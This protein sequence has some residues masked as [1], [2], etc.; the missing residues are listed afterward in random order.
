M[1]L[2]FINIAVQ[3][4]PVVSLV[5]KELLYNIIFNHNNQHHGVFEGHYAQDL[6]GLMQPWQQSAGSKDR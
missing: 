3:K 1:L 5:K 4:Y 2:V 6:G